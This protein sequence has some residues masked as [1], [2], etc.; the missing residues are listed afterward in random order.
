MLLVLVVVLLVLLLL[1]LLPPCPWPPGPAPAPAWWCCST[2]RC[3]PSAECER[4]TA[5]RRGRGG[6]EAG[7]EGSLSVVLFWCVL[8][9]L[10]RARAGCC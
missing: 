3:C 5:V 9:A 2:G 8:G 7:V 1:L 4:G 10:A 6:E